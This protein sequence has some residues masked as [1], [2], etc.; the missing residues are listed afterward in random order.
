MGAS[1]VR[2]DGPVERQVSAG[3]I[4]DRLGLDLDEFDPPEAGVSKVV[5]RSSK[6]RS[7]METV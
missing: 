3:R 7:G 1:P 4:D 5:L 2:V 6:S